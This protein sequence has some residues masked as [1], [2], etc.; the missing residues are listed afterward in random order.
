MLLLTRDALVADD[1]EYLCHW[2]GASSLLNTDKRALLLSYGCINTLKLINDVYW[3]SSDLE[4][5]V[6]HRNG[7]LKAEILFDYVLSK[8]NRNSVALRTISCLIVE[9]GIFQLLD[10]FRGWPGTVHDEIA[11]VN[12]CLER[13]HIEDL[14]QL[15]F[16]GYITAEDGAVYLQSILDSQNPLQAYLSMSKH[17]YIDTKNIRHFTLNDNCQALIEYLSRE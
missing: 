14:E 6:T 13:R 12:T 8:I 16:R 1:T 11:V 5:V 9:N 17:I 3:T 4:C 7:H 10:R 15:A 2:Y